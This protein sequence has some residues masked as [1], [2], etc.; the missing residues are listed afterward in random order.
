M[1]ENVRKYKKFAVAKNEKKMKRLISKSNLK[2]IHI[3]DSDVLIFEFSP[4]KVTLNKPIFAGMVCLELAKLFMYQF[5]FGRMIPY[6]G[7]DNIVLLYTDTDS[8]IWAIYTEDLY[9]DLQH[10]ESEFDFSKYPQNHPLHNTQNRSI[11]GKWKDELQGEIIK[12]G[13][14][15]RSKA[16]SI[17][18]FS[19]T[20]STAAG[21][22][23]SK[24][25]TKFWFDYCKSKKIRVKKS[26]R[27]YLQ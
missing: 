24:F 4:L 21:V 6:F 12:E 14:F 10:F 22:K 23:K 7:R 11:P 3:I 25:D 17:E 9:V 16:Y 26:Q 8:F 20:I 13:I 1:I 27:I 18:S 2:D 5:H 15:L 19:K